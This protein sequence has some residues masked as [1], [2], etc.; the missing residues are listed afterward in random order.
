MT[1]QQINFRKC[2][3]NHCIINKTRFTSNDFH[4]IWNAMAEYMTCELPNTQAQEAEAERR[5][6]INGDDYTDGERNGFEAG[7]HWMHN[8]VKELITIK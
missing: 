3:D 5:H 8:K 4:A 7:A 6:P 1:D 2:L